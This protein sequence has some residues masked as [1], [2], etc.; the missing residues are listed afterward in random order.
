MLPFI[1]VAL[2]TGHTYEIPVQPIADNRAQAML[3]LHPDEFSTIEESRLDTTELFEDSNEIRDWALNQMNPP[4]YMPHARLIRYAPPDVDMQT[5]EWTYHKE[6]ALIP[7]IDATEVL[8]MPLELSVQAMALHQRVCQILKL[9][10]ADGK[11]TAAVILVSGGESVVNTFTGVLEHLVAR[12]LET[13][14]PAA[15]NDAANPT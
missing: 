4:E 1:R 11:P 12:A 15:G 7:Q 9:N 13:P 5:G 10:D 6:P 2:P 14:I 3:A 8:A